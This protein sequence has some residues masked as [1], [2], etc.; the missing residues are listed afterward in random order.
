MSLIDYIDLSGFGIPRLLRASRQAAAILSFGPF[1]AFARVES[2]SL[3]ATRTEDKKVAGSATSSAPTSARASAHHG[4]GNYQFALIAL[5]SLFFM[6]G[7][8]TCLNDILVPHLKSVFQ[9]N[10]TQA[11]LIQLCFC[12]CVHDDLLFEFLQSFVSFGC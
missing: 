9:L 8:I 10:Y 3:A 12:F 5:T 4:Q 7:F 1:G 6:W 2:R 11:M